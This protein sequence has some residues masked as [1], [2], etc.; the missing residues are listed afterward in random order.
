MSKLILASTSPRRLEL[1]KQIG[2]TPDGVADPAVDETPLKAERPHLYAQRMAE[3]KAKAIAPKYPDAY[4]L[5]GDTVAAAG[6]RILPKCADEKEVIECLKLT[7]GRR[8]RIYGGVSLIA[9]GKG[10]VTRLAQ[11]IVTFRRLSD[12]EISTY[13]A[14]GE[15]IGKAGG[16]ALQ[17]R[18]AAFIRFVSGSPSNVIGL[19]LFEAAR[20][21]ESAGYACPSR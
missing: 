2:I 17:G 7:S 19:P 5:A 6:L 12:K 16:Y 15:G 10:P 13:A 3:A 8:H 9:P 18:A 1:L 20:L 11:S 14:S 4:I 21:L